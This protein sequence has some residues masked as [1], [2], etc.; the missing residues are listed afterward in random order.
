MVAGGRG[1]VA[2]GVVGDRAVDVARGGVVVGALDDVG[3]GGVVVTGGSGAVARG[4][5]GD[6]AVDVTRGVVVG[7]LDDSAPAVGW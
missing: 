1:A 4:A 2:R 6:R 7:A 5:V 3:A